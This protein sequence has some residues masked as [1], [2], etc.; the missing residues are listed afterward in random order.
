MNNKIRVTVILFLSGMLLLLLGRFILLSLIESRLESLSNYYED[1]NVANVLI[2]N[3]VGDGSEK[4]IEDLPIK[5]REDVDRII[6]YVKV[7]S[8]LQS[9]VYLYVSK[10]EKLGVIIK[11]QTSRQWKNSILFYYRVN[12]LFSVNKKYTSNLIQ[13]NQYSTL[14]GQILKAN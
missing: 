13:S 10:K 3:Q 6:R 2:A 14:Y 4:L 8:G 1:V 11:I 12:W 9:R 5:I 7:Y